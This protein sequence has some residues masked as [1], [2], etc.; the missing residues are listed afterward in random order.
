MPWKPDPCCPVAQQRGLVF[1]LQEVGAS[2]PPARPA[3]AVLPRTSTARTAAIS[4]RVQAAV[5]AAEAA[6]EQSS[7]PGTSSTF[8]AATALS[9]NVGALSDSTQ[10]AQPLIRSAKASLGEGRAKTAEERPT[11][12]K[13]LDSAD[14]PKLAERELTNSDRGATEEMSVQDTRSRKK[15][16]T[17]QEEQPREL[18]DLSDSHHAG[19]SHLDASRVGEREE[20]VAG[21]GEA[22][23]RALAVSDDNHAK[24]RRLGNGV[25]GEGKRR[26]Q[27]GGEAALDEGVNGR[28]EQNDNGTSGRPSDAALPEG[29]A[30]AA[31]TGP[32]DKQHAQV[33]QG[34]V[35]PERLP[36]PQGTAEASE[37]RPS[38]RP[39][40]L[41]E[42]AQPILGKRKMETLPKQWKEETS[43]REIGGM[44]GSQELEATEEIE[45]DDMDPEGRL[46]ESRKAWEAIEGTVHGEVMKQHSPELTFIEL[47]KRQRF[48]T[49]FAELINFWPVRKPEQQPPGSISLLSLAVDAGLWSPP[50]FYRG[51]RPWIGNQ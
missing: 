39:K 35:L 29:E 49:D 9:K 37:S 14:L 28:R 51:K 21:R 34:S 18:S 25:H 6:R 15:M 1:H 44:E 32:G 38:G 13:A 30:E 46:L 7:Q 4:K 33:V 36:R 40:Q 43:R 23:S 5:R 2:E 41:E 16:G 24:E 22:R 31:H 20:K 45:D 47:R 27:E 11:V 3:A 42:E 26:Q 17:A 10:L 50:P 12:A 19:L 8:T 48:P